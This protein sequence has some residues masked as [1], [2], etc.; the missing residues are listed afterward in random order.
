MLIMTTPLYPVFSVGADPKQAV[1]PARLYAMM[2]AQ[3]VLSALSEVATQFRD[4]FWEELCRQVQG[5]IDQVIS[6]GRNR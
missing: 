5:E 2:F 3:S 1:H 6:P 4:G